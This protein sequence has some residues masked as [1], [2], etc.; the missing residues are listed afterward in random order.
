[1]STFELSDGERTARVHVRNEA[2]VIELAGTIGL[3]DGSF[4]E[5]D[6]PV[7]PVDRDEDP[8]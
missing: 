8:E 2:D 7:G 3:T 4:A 1:M 5:T 6:G